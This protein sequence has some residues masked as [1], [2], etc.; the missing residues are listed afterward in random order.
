MKMTDIQN[1]AKS[2]GIKPGKMKKV[3]LIRTIQSQEGNFS[4]FQTNND[5][6]CSQESCCW[7]D[8]CLVQ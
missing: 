5:G 7:R 4:C 1:K 8:D 2:L 3:E 6:Q